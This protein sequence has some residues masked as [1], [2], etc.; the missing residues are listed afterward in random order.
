MVQRPG[1]GFRLRRGERLK[2]LTWD[3]DGYVLWY[4]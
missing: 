3:R 2:V 1:G 4:K